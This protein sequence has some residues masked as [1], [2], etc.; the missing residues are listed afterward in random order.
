MFMLCACAAQNRP[1]QLI[2]GAGPVHPVA[3]KTAGVEGV[4][5]IRYDVDVNGNVI[6]ARVV[7]SEPQGVFDAA[8][9]EAVRSWRFNAPIVNGEAQAA[10]NIEST[11]AFRLSGTDEYDKY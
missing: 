4:V 1:L 8:A 9:L 7:R 10:R 5:A 2:S 3:A 6:N 11:V